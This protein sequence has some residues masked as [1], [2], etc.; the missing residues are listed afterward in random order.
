[1]PGILRTVGFIGRP[2]NRRHSEDKPSKASSP[3]S[4]IKAPT[5]SPIESLEKVQVVVIP[6]YEKLLSEIQSL[7]QWKLESSLKA[8]IV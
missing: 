3:Y 8:S 4:N 2:R 6:I 1:M 5:Y 7:L